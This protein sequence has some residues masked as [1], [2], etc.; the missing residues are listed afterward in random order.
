VKTKWIAG[1][2]IAA[3]V[4]AAL[5]GFGSYSL[6][7]KAGQAQALAARQSFLAARG[8][9]GNGQAAFGGQGGGGQFNPNNFAAGQVKQ[10]DGN[11]IQLSTATA[12]VTVKISDQTQ[13]Q[14]M[15]SGTVSDIQVGERL[16][17]QGTKGADGVF[18]AERIQIG[19]RTDAGTSQ[20]AQGGGGGTRQA[21]G[22]GTSGN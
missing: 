16:T 3:V 10:V 19:G 1:V 15:A 6:G 8:I 17:V 2:V 7:V 22:S 20:Q 21:Q 4:I 11:T 18:S 5:V 9:G 12:V 13:I 14:K